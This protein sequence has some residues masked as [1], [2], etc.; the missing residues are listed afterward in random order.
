VFLLHHHWARILRIILRIFHAHSQ[1]IHHRDRIKF[2]LVTDVQTIFP[3][4]KQALFS[5][6][7]KELVN[8][9]KLWAALQW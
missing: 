8:R 3:I 6:S 7:A 2:A 1:C 4:L 9:L 5:F